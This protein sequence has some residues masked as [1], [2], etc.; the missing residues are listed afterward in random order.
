MPALSRF[1]KFAW[2]VLVYNMLIILWGGYVRASGSGAGCGEHWPVCNGQIIPRDPSIETLVEFSHRLTTGLSGLVA[3]A[4]GVWAFRAF[5]RRHRVRGAAAATLGLIILEGAVGAIQ[6]LLGLTA[7][8]ASLARG[9]IGGI[10]LVNTFLLL[11][12]MT[13]TAWWASGGKPVQ[14]R[15]QNGLN[16]MLGAGLFGLLLIGATGAIT[17]LG[18]TLFPAT[19]LRDGVLQDFSPTAH[20]FIQLRIYHPVMAVLM[21][22]YTVIMGRVVRSRRPSPLTNRLS[23]VLTTL[24]LAQLVIGVVNVILL[25]PTWM[26][27]VHLAMADFVWIAYVLTTAAALAVPEAL[28]ARQPIAAT[29]Q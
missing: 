16:W 22:A 20:L 26:Q 25:A 1:A 23:H 28:R 13:L 5:P 11:G 10:H 8:N 7:D 17:A 27:I 4:L 12:A 15:N 24:F 29:A 19:S 9:W 21:G 18:D 2:A 14:W 6:V 3:I